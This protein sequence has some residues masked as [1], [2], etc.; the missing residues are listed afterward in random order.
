MT[1]I[2]QRT[3]LGRSKR[4]E[5]GRERGREREEGREREGGRGREGEIETE[6][7]VYYYYYYS[8]L[9]LLVYISKQ[10]YFPNVLML[11]VDI[12]LKLGSVN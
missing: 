2:Q 4:R 9:C 6:R 11:S 3:P 7:E 12:F 5:G 10:K 1:W 8:C